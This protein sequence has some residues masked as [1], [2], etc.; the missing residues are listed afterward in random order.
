[1]ETRGLP[2]RDL[3]DDKH[4]KR[5]APTTS[6]SLPK[7]RSWSMSIP[8]RPDRYEASLARQAWAQVSLSQLRRPRH[9]PQIGRSRNSEAKPQSDRGSN[10][11]ALEKA[12]GQSA[13]H[14]REHDA[15]IE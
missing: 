6:A 14:L 12:V 7:N 1:C 2:R 3:P 9:S 15:G 8:L 5:P 13:I 11:V 10:V 4:G